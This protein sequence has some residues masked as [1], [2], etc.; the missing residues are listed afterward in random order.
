[1][2]NQAINNP[3]D[4]GEAVRALLKADPV[5]AD[6]V[7]PILNRLINN[8]AYLKEFLEIYRQE[9]VAASRLGDGTI[10]STKLATATDADKVKLANL[11][12]EVIDAMTGTT[13]VGT[14]PGD[15]SVTTPKLGDKAVTLEKLSDLV[16]SNLVPFQPAAKLGRDRDASWPMQLREGIKKVELY[17]ADPSKFYSLA[18]LARGRLL[19]DGVTKN[20]SISIW[21]V[22]AAGGY[23]KQ[24]AE[25]IKSNSVYAEPLG[26]TVIELNPKTDEGIKGKVWVDWTKFTDGV[27][28]TNLWYPDTG[29]SY[30]A[31]I[32]AMN[33]IT[34]K[35]LEASLKVVLD[36]VKKG[37]T[38][39]NWIMQTATTTG[40]NP[41][42]S[43][44]R[45]WA[46]AVKY[47]GQTFK[48][49]NIHL[50]PEFDNQEMRLIIM[51]TAYTRLF[52]VTD[53]VPKRG[54][55]LFVFPKEID[56]SPY[57]TNGVFYIAFETVDP[58]KR[59]MANY[60]S[61]VNTTYFAG[62]DTY[63]N[64]YNTTSNANWTVVSGNGYDRYSLAA[65]F[66]K[67]ADLILENSE[68]ARISQVETDLA[69]L[70]TDVTV[71][72]T[73]DNER[74]TGT[75]GVSGDSETAVLTAASYASNKRSDPFAGWA[76]DFN[77][78]ADLDF[79]VVKLP[80][81]MRSST[82]HDDPGNDLWYKVTLEVKDG[83]RTGNVI[84]VG[85]TYVLETVEEL[86][87]EILLKDPVT[88]APKT[89]TAAD[90]V[91][92]TYFIGYKA[93]NKKGGG[94]VIGDVQGAIST[95]A[96]TSWYIRNTN[97]NTNTWEVYS[98]NPSI[99]I[100]HF[101]ITN[102]K[103]VTDWYPSKNLMVPSKEQLD[104]NTKDIEA[105]TTRVSTAET[106][107]GSQGTRLTTAEGN[108]SSQGTRLTAAEGDVSN[109]KTRMTTA[110]S[111]IDK[112]ETRV[113]AVEKPALEIF[114]PPKVYAVTGK[115]MNIYFDNLIIEDADKY[116][117]D[118]VCSIGQQ[119]NERWTD[120][121]TTPGTYDLTVNVYKDTVTLLASATTKIIVTDAAAGS[122][123]NVSM[124]L[125]GDSTTANG[126]YAGELVALYDTDVMTATLLGTR[127]TGAA[128]HEG[129]GGWRVSTY[130][131]QAS[132]GGTENPFYN[133]DVGK[134]DFPYYM[135]Q[136]GYTGVEFVTFHLGINDIFGQADDGGVESIVNTAVTYYEYMIDSIKT[137]DPNIK[138]GMAIAILPSRH[139]DSFGNN[140]Q[141]G[142]N[143]W[144]Y[145]RNILIWNR[146]IQ[147]A[148]KDREAEG[149][150]L[151]PLNVNLDTVHNMPKTTVA[152]N[153]RTT[154]T[155][156]RQTNG[157]HPDATG[158]YQMA[159][160][161]YYFFKSFQV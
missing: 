17:G 54:Y 42:S 86:N 65:E 146:V 11:A 72:E 66:I 113:T 107:I 114:L 98:G 153:S 59:S 33:S 154:E 137:F 48:A 100:E 145:K 15:G 73:R 69:A 148:F 81:I 38:Y 91:N 97:I 155:V 142:Q 26:V 121:P 133:P 30:Q 102:P 37:L 112:V 132:S 115:E 51:D 58:T 105:V 139:Q 63:K 103:E 118:V 122:G 147:A 85:E 12:Q 93:Y 53:I 49:V 104:K 3:K 161:F 87:L 68:A 64:L 5:H 157:V 129:R 126:I 57:I 21:E 150:Y 32:P 43:T 56:L 156:V 29:F 88:K 45:G 130:Y 39:D 46:S 119:Q 74:W 18:S 135:N 41:P 131:N 50:N 8:D 67:E 101:K 55:H 152:A 60:D 78:T 35:Q 123:N 84:A 80:K 2:A 22:D 62:S 14:T 24:V 9:T 144:R 125:V 36:I 109:L 120:K 28:M 160:T 10:P 16:R 71:L 79:N 106:N 92:P 70:E 76:A 77:K 61:V 95:F 82:V 6:L 94:A 141:A 13:Q 111:D 90:I 140:Y 158:Y 19:A 83:G 23:V 149:I 128:L 27:Y 138:I 99:A 96:G 31:T 116:L 47:T 1:M 136:Q 124:L 75:G 143:R 89:I 127:G 34:T 4:F 25:F 117:W 134:W 108:I 7:N 151:V 40:T 20:W 110:E 52:E 44:F 159:D